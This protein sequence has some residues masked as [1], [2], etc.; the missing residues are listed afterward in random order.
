M[1]V[2][3][4]RVLIVDDEKDFCQILFI[5]LKSEG[6]DPMVAHSGEAAIEMIRRGMPDAM[7]L[8]V[9]MPG[10]DGFEVLKRSKKLAAHL[11][12]IMMTG[13][14][15][16]H[17]AVHAIKE[18]ADDYLS[19]PI[20][21][22]ELIQKL[23]HLIANRPPARKKRSASGS[24]KD[25]SA[26][27][28]AEIMGPSD[29]VAKI[30]SDVNL[31]AQSDFTVIIQGETG[32]GKELVSRAIHQSS[33]RADAHL[34]PL[35]CGAVPET[36]FES[37]LFGHERGAFT[38]AVQRRPGKFEMAQRGTLLLDEICNMPLNCQVKLL[39]A[40]QELSFF[41]VGGMDPLTVDVRLLV[42]SNQD[43]LLRSTQGSFSRDLYYRLSEFT[44]FIPPLKERREDIVHLADRFLGTTNLEL[45]KKVE[46]FS[47]AAMEVLIGYS[48]PGNV[49]QLR[50]T[51]RR[52]V[53]QAN[54]R[55]Q[56]EHLFIEDPAWE[57][58]TAVFP[59]PQDVGWDG[60]SLKDIVR[61]ST[62]EV[63]CRVLTQAL[64]KTRGN[65]AEAARLL[66][67]DYKTMHTKIK[68]YCIKIFPEDS[69]DQEK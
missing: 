53:L 60:L 54:Q 69:H 41:R 23:K 62:G 61:Q 11:P 26:L 67:V 13:F 63:E 17:G 27:N 51:I 29:S 5:V 57:I 39:R 8:D 50:S 66:R 24:G 19:K 34:V 9:R 68:Q 65:K 14:G 1:V 64:R 7:L 59:K 3:P 30:I 45:N 56:P 16:V 10:L 21:N 37:E 33:S 52:A 36:L 31:V 15:G 22:S 49:R 2:N 25:S 48:W 35:D 18:G 40:I 42:A 47:D 46:G 44:I 55:V 4:G 28:L 6:F 12:V 20:D 43:L 58:E 32:T 38:G